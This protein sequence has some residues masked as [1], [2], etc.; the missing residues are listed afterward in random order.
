MKR[1][2]GCFLILSEG[3]GGIRQLTHFFLSCLLSG[4]ARGGQA[5]ATCGGEGTWAEPPHIMAWTFGLQVGVT[6]PSVQRRT[7]RPRA[8]QQASA[9]LQLWEGTGSRRIG[10]SLGQNALLTSSRPHPE[11][12]ANCCFGRVALINRFFRS[13]ILYSSTCVFIYLKASA[14]CGGRG[15]AVV[16]CV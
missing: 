1:I 12:G 13:L 3:C 10:L 7:L 8:S 5:S 4:A 6:V 2:K 14:D 16:A 15:P 11:G 9:G